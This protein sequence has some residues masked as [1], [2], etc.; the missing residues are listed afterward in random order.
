MTGPAQ[1]RAQSKQDFIAVAAPWADTFSKAVTGIA[2]A[3][4]ASG[5]LTVSVYD[6]QF[7]FVG[8]DLFR[9]RVVVAGAWF[10][11]FASI[12]IFGARALRHASTTRL[13]VRVAGLLW[14]TYFLTSAG[15]GYGSM[16]FTQQR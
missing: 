2:V 12:P 11:L 9:P 10:F 8:T 13:M 1:E 16:Y 4:Y 14:S 5:F 3:L 7:G 15:L 6:S